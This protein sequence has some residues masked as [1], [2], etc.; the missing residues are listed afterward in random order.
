M[1][2]FVSQNVFQIS[3]NFELGSREPILICKRVSGF[4]KCEQTKNQKR[5]QPFLQKRLDIVI[6]A[7]TGIYLKLCEQTYKWNQIKRDVCIL[8]IQVIEQKLV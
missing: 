8:V 2:H 1:R 4:L 6:I 7:K 5:K 3:H